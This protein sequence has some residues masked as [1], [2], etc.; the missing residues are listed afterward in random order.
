MLLHGS[1]NLAETKRV[2]AMSA[3]G[4]AV[5]ERARAL[6]TSGEFQYVYQIERYLQMEG[7]RGVD[8]TFRVNPDLRKELRGLIAA[9]RLL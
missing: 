8:K 7:V 5:A 9:H 4:G 1:P 3:S 2:A 6:A